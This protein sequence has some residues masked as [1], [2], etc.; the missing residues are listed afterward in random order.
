MSKRDGGPAFPV[1]VTQDADGKY[2]GVQTA[3]SAGWCTGV[4]VRDYFA[5]AALQ[6]WLASSSERDGHPPC[7]VAAACF[8]F[9]DAMLAERSKTEGA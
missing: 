3:P 6:G 5:A 7:S 9:A 8:V 2:A 1:E 4:S